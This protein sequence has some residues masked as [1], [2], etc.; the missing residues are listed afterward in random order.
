MGQRPFAAYQLVPGPQAL[1]QS[2]LALREWV[3]D[4]YYRLRG[5]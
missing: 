2:H 3:S 4:L 1:R 5:S